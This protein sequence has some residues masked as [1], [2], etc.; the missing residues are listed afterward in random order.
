MHH[1]GVDGTRCP[2]RGGIRTGCG[3][4]G[5]Y[6]CPKKLTTRA[7]AMAL[8]YRALMADVPTEWRRERR[9]PLVDGGKRPCYNESKSS[10]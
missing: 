10:L 6:V 4:S 2:D 3:V 7:E 5:R 9:W 1:P 8:L